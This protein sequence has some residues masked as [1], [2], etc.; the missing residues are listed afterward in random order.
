V[1]STSGLTVV[2]KVELGDWDWDG[3]GAGSEAAAGGEDTVRWN[4]VILRVEGMAGWRTLRTARYVSRGGLG[5]FSWYACRRSDHSP[6]NI[7]HIHLTDLRVCMPAAS[8]SFASSVYSSA[9]ICLQNTEHPFLGINKECEDLSFKCCSMGQRWGVQYD[10]AQN[11][12][13]S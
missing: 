9:T 7:D 5:S 13:G 11:S 12:T 8:N 3:A 1:N 10:Q 4:R 6:A 2:L